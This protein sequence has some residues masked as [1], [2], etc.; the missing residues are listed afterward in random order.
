M[1]KNLAWPPQIWK[2][3]LVMVPFTVGFF[4][5]QIPSIILTM[6]ESEHSPTAVTLQYVVISITVVQVLL[7]FSV[8]VV[9][10]TVILENGSRFNENIVGDFFTRCQQCLD[11]F[12]TLE[13]SL[14]A[15]FL[16]FYSCIQFLSVFIIFTTLTRFIRHSDLNLYDYVTSGGLFLFMLC[17]MYNLLF[18]TK[19]TDRTFQSMQALG[20]Q[21]QERLLVTREKTERQSLKYLMK[22]VEM[23]KPL[24][25]CGYFDIAKTTLTSMVSVR[26]HNI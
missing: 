25:A 14:G 6:P 10:V 20:G 8:T 11:S 2:M 26:Y 3:F 23:L 13:S 18:L 1:N 15:F 5:Y 22:R 24:N 16:V 7:T 9:F 17:L 19:M 12:G 4:T 21:I